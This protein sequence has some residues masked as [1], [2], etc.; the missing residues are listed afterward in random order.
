MP[1]LGLS[2]VPGCLNMTIF[3]DIEVFDFAPH[4]SNP[5]AAQMDDF[6]LDSRGF[7]TAT[8]WKPTSLLRRTVKL[9]FLIQGL[10]AIASLRQFADR[11]R[12][13]QKPFW[14][15][16]WT[17]DFTPIADAAAGAGTITTSGHTFSA[18]YDDRNC[19]IALLTRAGKLECYGIT[20]VDDSGTDDVLTTDRPLD[21]A[22]DAS[23][24]AISPLLMA[25]FAEDDL[26]WEYKAGDV[27]AANLSFVELAAEYPAADA[28]GAL[29][30]AHFGTRPVFLY[31][32][33]DGAT[34]LHL[35]DYGVD[36]TAASQTWQAADIRHGDLRSAR[37]LLGDAVTLTIRTD[38]LTHPLRAYLNEFNLCHFT[39]DIFAADMDDLDALDLSAPLHTGVLQSVEFQDA[40][41][42]SFNVSSIFR[43]GEREIPT[44]RI[45]RTCN[46]RTYDGIGCQ[47]VS[48]DFA[49]TGT[50]TAIQSASPPW[51]EAAEFGAKAAAEADPDW[52]ALGRV[53]AGNEVRICTGASG[54]R[55]YLNFAFSPGVAIGNSITALAGDNKRV[56]TCD[57]KFGQLANH[58]G[59]PYAPNSNP[60]IA[61]LKKTNNSGGKKGA[62][63]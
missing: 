57:A 26:S 40:G 35:A 49:T 21:T 16:T 8:P 46:W 42:I 17:S 59:A 24:T 55:L 63:Q 28:G 44:M 25:R 50:I 54:N 2:V 30:S 56:T 13:R 14:L 11:H 10:S 3:R 7:G 52:F 5:E 18:R 32:I 6:T 12:G 45:Q 27:M 20:S 47:A 1:H 22:L 34:T 41:A 61:A 19:F 9:P 62:S 39:C 37:D 58:S 48:A 23:S 4:F 29:D 43:L 38:A 31:R 36:V 60:Q 51:V 33:T 15:P 53:T